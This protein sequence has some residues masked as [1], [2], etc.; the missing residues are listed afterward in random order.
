ME[1]NYGNGLYNDGVF[2]FTNPGLYKNP[3]PIVDKENGIDTTLDWTALWNNKEY[4]FK[5]KMTAPL[6]IENEPP[7]N[8]Q[9]IRRKF[10]FQYAQAVFH[11]SAKYKKLVKEGGYVPAT[12]NEDEEF[13]SIIQAC[14]TPLP[15]ASMQIKSLPRDS[16]ENYKGT[17]AVTRGQDLSKLFQDYEIPEL[18][19]M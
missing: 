11:Q 9:T 17:K 16:E 13:T 5:G 1:N 8:I 7:Q 6:I 3:K 15:K 18:G 14:L 4:I 10:A 19:Q 12:Y 2:Y